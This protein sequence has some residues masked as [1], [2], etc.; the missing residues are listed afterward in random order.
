MNRCLVQVPVLIV[1]LSQAAMC[2]EWARKMFSDVSHSFGTVAR[3]AKSEFNFDFTNIYKEDIHIASVRAS[4]GCVTPTITKQ[5]LKTWEKGAIN[6]RFNTD[7]FLGQRAASITVTIDQPFFAEVQLKIDGLIRGD[8]VFEPGAVL[9]GSIDQGATAER[10]IMVS[11]T[12]HDKW[13]IADVR[14]ANP[15]LQVEIVDQKR[16]PG[17][18]QYWLSVRLLEPKKTGFFRDQM[19]LVT[20]DSRASQLAVTIEGNVEPVLIVSPASLSLG[21]VAPGATVTKQLVVRSK[22]PFRIT[23][24][25]C[26]N[27]S[28]EFR[29]STQS[30]ELHLIPIKYTAGEEAGEL[31]CEIE[32]QTDRGP[33]VVG[34]CMATAFV[35][36]ADAPTDEL[37]LIEGSATTATVVLP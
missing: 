4:C 37:P 18:S 16:T 9:F 17:L 29:P 26:G 23:D 27:K 24:V 15:D 7:S 28:F 5:V 25:K 3:G 36:A 33:S 10:K 32:I 31:A 8:V 2:Q 20:N 6:V 30:K 21:T 34:T 22:Q 14:S 19:V 1:L 13:E 35:V 12:G 11:H